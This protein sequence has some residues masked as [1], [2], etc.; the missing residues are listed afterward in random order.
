MAKPIFYQPRPRWHF[1][2]SL[3]A[4]IALEAAAV[5]VASIHH[6]EA[7][8]EESGLFQQEPV[9]AVI[10]MEEAEPTPPPE[11]EPPPPPPPDEP[12]EFVVQEPTPPPRPPSAPTP[13]PRKKVATSLG[14]VPSS[15]NYVSAKA[16]MLSAPR[17]AYPYEARRSHIVGSGKFLI[18][19]DS[20]GNATDVEVTQSTG[21][22]ILDQVTTSTFRRWRCKPGIYSKVYVPITFTMAGAQF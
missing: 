21:N 10:T 1:I 7:I 17:P 11:E 13:P 4:A 6:E 16:N 14:Q 2:G 9:E 18:H 5:G 15:A 19:F 12:P 22:A 3:V 8:P 20:S